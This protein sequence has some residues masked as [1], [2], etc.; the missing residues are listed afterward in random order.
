MRALHASHALHGMHA[1]LQAHSFALRR[2]RCSR[3]STPLAIA[4]GPCFMIVRV[5]SH[6][7]RALYSV[8]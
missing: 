4:P 7:G 3:V 8:V 1:G 2:A 5:S 6:E